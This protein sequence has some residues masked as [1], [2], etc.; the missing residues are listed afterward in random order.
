MF[1]GIVAGLGGRGLHW[2]SEARKHE[3]CKLVGF[4]EPN[5]ANVKRA[6]EQHNVPKK[7]IFPSLDEAVKKVK[8]DFVLD[9]TPPCVHRE[10][11]EKAFA[12][13]MHLI[14][15][16]PLSDNWKDA[17]AMVKAGKK[18]GLRHMIT[19]NYRFSGEPRT[20]RKLIADGLVGKPGQLDVRF[21]MCWADFP[22]SHY[23]TQPYMFINDMMVH[24]FDMMRYVLGADAVA[25][26]ATTW[27]HPWGWHKGDAAH[28]IIF[29]FPD[30]LWATHVSVGCAVGER[31]S[32][33]GDW[34]IEGPGGSIS[35]KDGKIRYAHLH[36]TDSPVDKEVPHLAVPPAGK[37][38]L[39]EF[40]ASIEEK[41]DPECCATDN[42]KSL[43]M[44]LAAIQSAKE[45][46]R[47]TMDDLG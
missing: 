30:G 27:N 41:R 12:A 32:W 43:A 37:A 13:G 31:T 8:A 2:V 29:E 23:V 33:N 38:I 10:I 21:Y 16:K 19:Q 18:A 7:E 47:I 25:V 28:A 46:R 26:Q 45:K 1:K 14:G 3:N 36:R 5:E 35:W 17:K 11:A 20:T 40:F 15:E 9:V 24:H 39:D 6:V 44:T 22:G 42:I 4:V 34:R